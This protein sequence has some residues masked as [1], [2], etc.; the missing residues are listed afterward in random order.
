MGN[1]RIVKTVNDRMEVIEPLVIGKRVLDLGAVDS[2]RGKHATG[3]RLEKLPNLLFRHI[4]AVNPETIGVDVDEQGIAILREQGLKVVAADG[5]TMDLGER[6]DVI[7]AGEIIE[8]LENPGSFLR[9]MTKHLNADGVLLVSTPNPFYFKQVWKIFRKNRPQ[10]HEEHTCWFDPIT[11]TR[12]AGLCGLQ[13]V[14]G[15]W[16]QPR[17]EL[18]KSWPRLVR[19]YFSHSFMLLLK[20]VR[21]RDGGS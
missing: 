21:S 18:V 8:H 17:F 11:L 10:V 13:V 16:M 15:Y 12:L 20:P 3:D 9:N 4:C 7:I 6:F 14:D 19:S 1:V 5:T 2:R